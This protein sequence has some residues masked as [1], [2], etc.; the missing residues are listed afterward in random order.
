MTLHVY[1]HDARARSML[2]LG[3]RQFRRVTARGSAGWQ[4][5]TIILT[6]PVRR[7]RVLK[8]AVLAV[9]RLPNPAQCN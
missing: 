3:K 2:V 9:A 5:N 8:L 1:D 6:A 7:A 4:F